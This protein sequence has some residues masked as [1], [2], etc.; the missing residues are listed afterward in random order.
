M[1]DFKNNPGGFALLCSQEGVTE[2]VVRDDLGIENAAPEGKL[3]IDL[4]DSGSRIKSMNF[5]FDIKTKEVAYDHQLNVWVGDVLRT[6]SFVGVRLK[7]KILIIAANDQEEA[8]EFTRDLQHI[9]NEQANTIRQLMKEKMAR[10]K[11]GGRDEDFSY[12]DMSALNNELINLQR[13]LARKNADLQR[14]NNLKNQFL[15]MAAH[16]LRNPLAII[17]TQSQLLIEQASDNLPPKYLKFLNN[18]FSTAEFML[19]L[20]EDLLDVSKI[21]SGKLEL[22]PETFNLVDLVR[23]TV[24][25]NQVLAD[26]RNIRLRL[27]HSA[28]AIY[29]QG[30]WHK[31]VQVFNNLLSNAIKFSLFDSA[32]R[33]IL[34]VPDEYARISVEDKGQGIPS[35]NLEHIFKPFQNPAVSQ[36]TEEKGTG[37]GLNIA[38]RIVEGHQ[39]EMWVESEEGK[40]SAFRFTLPLTEVPDNTAE[41]EYASQETKASAPYRED[42]TLLLVED[43]FASLKLM[44]E[45]LKPL[46][47]S[48]I[49]CSYGKEIME[50]LRNNEG[51]G[52]I[53][54]DIDLPDM[55]GRELIRKIRESNTRMPIIVQTALASPND[56]E[57]TLAAGADEYLTKPIDRDVLF[58]KIEKYLGGK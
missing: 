51:I 36:A 49:S 19:R 40:G 1:T 37:L 6:L 15:G 23:H 4:M 57:S 52:L 26:R 13:E 8:M 14:V 41:E 7:D 28:D 22:N 17:Y 35:E 55:D 21:E 9:H 58:D 54:L 16:D 18:I 24:E 45:M 27:D 53:L 50:A 39:G 29:I 44:E 5:L 10:E 48:I 3:F 30:D 25:L 20:V 38:R 33:V 34:E 32:V 31:L 12:D 11:E 56:K 2:Q 43:D 47:G 46:V 42:K